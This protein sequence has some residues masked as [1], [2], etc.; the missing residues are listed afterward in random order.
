MSGITS[1]LS[2]NFYVSSVYR[3]K[4]QS[5]QTKNSYLKTKQTILG[6]K[7]PPLHRGDAA[8]AHGESAN[9][10]PSLTQ[11]NTAYALHAAKSTPDQ[12]AQSDA[13]APYAAR[14]RFSLLRMCYLMTT[15][16]SFDC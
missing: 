10:A 4:I 8:N 5:S 12:V 11:T 2:C 1:A 16:P 15:C 9:K 6:R 7:L 3:T 13:A 14:F